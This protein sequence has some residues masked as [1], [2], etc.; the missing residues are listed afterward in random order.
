MITPNPFTPQSGW[1]P[2]VFGGRDEELKYFQKILSESAVNRAN[3]I[4]VLGEWGTGKTSLSKQYKKI[5]QNIGYPASLCPISRINSKSHLKDA[6]SLIS[7]EM[8]AG[9]PQ[10]GGDSGLH[11]KFKKKGSLQ[12]QVQ[13]TKFLLDLWKYIRADL[14]VVLLDDIQNL[15][16]ESGVIDILRSVLSKEE[17]LKNTNYLFVLCSTPKGWEGFIDKHNPVG[18]FF[19][20]RV[21]LKSLSRIDTRKIIENSLKNTGVSF[22]E[23]VEE[24]VYLDALGHPYETQLLCSHLY[25]AQIEG[26]VTADIYDAVFKNALKELGRDYFEALF[27]RASEREAEVLAILMEKNRPMVIGDVR[28]VMITEKRAANFPIANVKNFLYRLEEKE[29]IKRN[30]KGE[31]EISDPMFLKYLKVFKS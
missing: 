17:I 23:K 28:S 11:E 19:R 9:F 2:R 21:Y 27:R 31:F 6:I 1:E 7:E 13:F 12:P 8:L 29:L 20:K 25:D 3:H 18:R 14:A 24:R 30:E 4:V 5:S 10:A 16:V 22:S 26:Q 15:D